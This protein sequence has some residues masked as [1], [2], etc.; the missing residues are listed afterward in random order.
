MIGQERAGI[1]YPGY[2]GRAASGDGVQEPVSEGSTEARHIWTG[3]K[4]L[5][6]WGVTQHLIDI[7][8]RR[9]LLR[10]SDIACKP[11]ARE[12]NY[13]G[14]VF[15]AGE[16]SFTHGCRKKLDAQLACCIYDLAYAGS[17]SVAIT[18]PCCMRAH[19]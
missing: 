10:L 1:V 8:L 19:L 6:W 4:R 15:P 17:S 13:H 12:S 11:Q 3:A 2:D 5:A 18:G 14:E 16:R 7:M 9:S